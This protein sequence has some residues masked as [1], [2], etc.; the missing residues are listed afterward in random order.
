MPDP[1]AERDKRVRIK[2]ARFAQC[3]PMFSPR[4]WTPRS[5]E[6]ARIFFFFTEGALRGA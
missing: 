3:E 6:L 5:V 1:F 2:E 4:H